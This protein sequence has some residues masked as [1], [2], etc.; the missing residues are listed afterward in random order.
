MA[1]GGGGGAG[2]SSDP[3]PMLFAPA[4]FLPA[5]RYH[6]VCLVLPFSKGK[7]D[8]EEGAVESWTKISNVRWSWRFESGAQ[9]PPTRVHR[10]VV[11]VSWAG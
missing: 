9:V 10:G 8:M 2:S 4:P 1:K 7:D 6:L 11:P 5:R 3:I